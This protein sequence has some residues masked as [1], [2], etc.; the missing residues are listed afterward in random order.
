MTAGFGLLGELGTPWGAWVGAVGLLERVEEAGLV[1]D[2]DTCVWGV[3]WG[4][5]SW[6]R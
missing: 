6:A 5:Q 1:G 3:L 2:A 4:A